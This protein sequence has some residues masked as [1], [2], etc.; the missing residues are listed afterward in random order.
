MERKTQPVDTKSDQKPDVAGAS[1]PNPPTSSTLPTREAVLQQA[2][3]LDANAPRDLIWIFVSYHVYR[4]SYEDF[5]K[6]QQAKGITPPGPMDP[7]HYI[8]TWVIDAYERSA[9]LPSRKSVVEWRR[10]FLWGGFLAGFV[11]DYGQI[12]L[13]TFPWEEFA[14]LAKECDEIPKFIR[15]W[16]LEKLREPGFCEALKHLNGLLDYIFKGRCSLVG[17]KPPKSV[18]TPEELATWKTA[19]GEGRDRALRDLYNAIEKENAGK[20]N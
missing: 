4:I 8:K 18:I 6:T 12:I 7:D 5:E 13:L 2:M 3:S 19:L 17:F 20:K 1:V 15:E 16:I 14:E 9:T 10:K 11:A